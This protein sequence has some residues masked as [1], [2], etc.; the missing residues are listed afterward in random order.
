MRSE[1][2]GVRNCCAS[3]SRTKRSPN[4]EELGNEV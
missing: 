4:N 2:L 1:E 3:E